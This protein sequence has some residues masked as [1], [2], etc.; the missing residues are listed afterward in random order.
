MFR[1]RLSFSTSGCQ[2]EFDGFPEIEGPKIG[3]YD[4][5]DYE[6]SRKGL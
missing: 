3:L 1:A 5:P 4:D 2:V 6:D